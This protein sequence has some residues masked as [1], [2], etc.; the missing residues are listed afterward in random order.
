MGRNDMDVPGTAGIDVPPI[1]VHRCQLKTGIT[2]TP[3]FEKKGLATH[4]INVGTKCG[5]N[6]L[7]CSTGAVLRTHQSFRACGENPFDTGYAIVDPETPAR[8]ARAAGRIRRRGLVQLCTLTDAWAPEAREHQLGRRCLEAIL[9]QPDWTVR[10]L[11]NEGKKPRILKITATIENHAGSTQPLLIEPRRVELSATR[12]KD[13]SN[14]TFTLTNLTDR[15]LKLRLV[16]WPEGIV[17]LNLPE[18]LAAGE[19]V[20]ARATLIDQKDNTSFK[21]SFTIE[22]DGQPAIRYSVPVICRSSSLSC[23]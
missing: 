11:T 23:Q 15:Q 9:S 5:H 8:V 10:I 4:A 13:R 17:D 6:C 12:E 2:R 1:R 19:T 22:V 7:Y 20:K 16:D 14:H 21:K 18:F 3:E